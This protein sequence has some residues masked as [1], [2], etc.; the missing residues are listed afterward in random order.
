[1]EKFLVCR[2]AVSGSSKTFGISK[3]PYVIKK[4][5]SFKAWQ[6]EVSGSLF[7]RKR[8]KY[9]IPAGPLS[10]WNTS[11][12]KHLRSKW[13]KV[14]LLLKARFLR[15]QKR[16]RMLKLRLNRFSLKPK[17][18]L[19][20][21]FYLKAIKA[22]VLNKKESYFKPKIKLKRKKLQVIKIKKLQKVT[23]FACLNDKEK[24]YKDIFF[25]WKTRDVFLLAKSSEKQQHM[26]LKHRLYYLGYKNKYSLFRKNLH[27]LYNTLLLQQGKFMSH[28]SSYKK[29]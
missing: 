1:M 25:K 22:D 9:F 7:F 11:V 18:I 10:S 16:F 21:K 27:A 2:R 14:C 24:K 17:F 15:R 5:K 8:K 28:F 4:K 13:H 3:K 20:K 23:F 6:E 12:M 29:I 26:H 19:N